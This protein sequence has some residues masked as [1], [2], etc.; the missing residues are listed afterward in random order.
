MQLSD[1]ALIKWVIIL[2]KLSSILITSLSP[3]RFENDVGVN[4]WE[5]LKPFGDENYVFFLHS[6][7]SNLISVN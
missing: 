4:P 2:I 3:L 5:N 6:S 7:E 1:Y